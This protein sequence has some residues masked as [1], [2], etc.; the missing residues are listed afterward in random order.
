MLQELQRAHAEAKL[1]TDVDREAFVRVGAPT[2]TVAFNLRFQA[3][4]IH[5]LIHWC[6]P[7]F[8]RELSQGEALHRLQQHLQNTQ[9]LILDEMSMIG[10]QMMGRIDS[11]LEQAKSS[12]NSNQENLGGVSCVLVGDPAQCEA[13]TDQQIYDTVPHKLT[14]SDGDKQHVHLSN[15]GL[16]VYESFTKVVVLT[17]THRLTMIENPKSKLKQRKK[18]KGK[19]VPENT[20]AGGTHTQRTQRSQARTH[21]QIALLVYRTALTAPH[22]PHLTPPHLTSLARHGPP[23]NPMKLSDEANATTFA[24]ELLEPKKTYSLAKIDAEAEPSLVELTF[25]VSPDPVEE[26]E[27][28]KE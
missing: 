24:Y 16:E 26:A 27:V 10:R 22:A 25:E 4:T 7:P 21:Q 20:A 12:R 2:G 5:R 23:G 14:S 9:L 1:P 11:R 8:F 18:S 3:T 17:K 6:T 13:I 15:R 28:A 19:I